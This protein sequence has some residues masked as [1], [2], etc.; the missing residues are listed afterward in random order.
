M[1]SRQPRWT[2]PKTH[3][4]AANHSAWIDKE[5]YVIWSTYRHKSH[6]E[7]GARDLSANYSGW[8]FKV[9]PLR[10]DASHPYGWCRHKKEPDRG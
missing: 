5:H 4:V 2:G 3:A 1:A 6:A 7:Q 9:V 8:D 10:I